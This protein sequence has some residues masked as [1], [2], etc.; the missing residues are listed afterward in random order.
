MTH[1]GPTGTA[2]VKCFG[3]CDG[4]RHEVDSDV[5]ETIDRTRDTSANEQQ[6]EQ[7]SLSD[8]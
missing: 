3:K 5:A 6:E 2:V 1:V 4:E 8:W 7:T